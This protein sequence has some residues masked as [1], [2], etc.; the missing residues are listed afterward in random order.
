VFRLRPRFWIVL[1]LLMSWHAP[2]FASI[3]I[4]LHLAGEDHTREELARELALAA[5]H[6]HHHEFDA[7]P[8]DH[9][10]VRRTT[11]PTAP[12]PEAVD[13]AA[14]AADAAPP[15]PVGRVERLASPPRAG[16][17]ELFYRHCALRL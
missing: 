13:L 9:S 11:A 5:S 14:M 15:A 3:G 2:A 7:T 8:H 17:P 6:G 12:A 1:V 16:P 4:G 10:A